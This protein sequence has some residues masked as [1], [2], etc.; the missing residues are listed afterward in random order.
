MIKRKISILLTVV[1]LINTMTSNVLVAERSM[2]TGETS[3]GSDIYDALGID[4]S[5]T[6]DGYNP[7]STEN[8][9]GKDTYVPN[10]VNELYDI[11]TN[12][13]VGAFTSVSQDKSTLDALNMSKTTQPMHLW[14][15][16]NVYG[17][18][19]N[20]DFDVFSASPINSDITAT[21]TLADAL[22][23]TYA[24]HPIK[25]IQQTGYLQ[26]SNL[27]SDKEP[28]VSSAVEGNFSGNSTGRE[29][30]VVMIY[31]KNLNRVNSV[32]I[33]IGSL[34][35]DENWTFGEETPI[36]DNQV[37]G[38]GEEGVGGRDNF[39]EAPFLLK[40][41][42]QI[43]TGDYNGDGIDEIAVYIP[44]L[45]KSRI[46]VYQLTWASSAE[47]YTDFGN[48]KHVWTHY[49]NETNYV[50]N[51]V[52]M[53]SG[54]VNS[55]NIDDLGVTWGYYYGPDDNK[56]SKA[57]IMFGE[58]TKMLQEH[59][60]ID[61]TYDGSSIVRS[62]FAFG[63][64]L[65][66]NKETLVLGGQLSTDIQNQNTT[67]RFITVYEWNGQDFIQS[68][69]LSRNFDLFAF[70]Q[71]TGR[72]IYQDVMFATSDGS[73][74]LEKARE[75][76]FLKDAVALEERTYSFYSSPLMPANIDI[77][78]NG[79]GKATGIYFDS[80]FFELN[81][82]DM[83]L[84]YTTDNKALMQNGNIDI[85]D[86]E[87]YVEYDLQVVDFTG[88][89]N[90]TVSTLA[91]YIN[92]KNTAS[93]TVI[94]PAT[95]IR[96]AYYK[97]WWN[98]LWKIKS[99]RD[100]VLEE[101]S[102]ENFSM[103]YIEKYAPTY[104]LSMNLDKSNT[105]AAVPEDLK[106]S[107]TN[108][109]FTSTL[110]SA[111]L[112]KNDTSYL[113]YTG[114]HSM[115][116][117][118][119]KVLAVVSS[120]PYF[121][122]LME[123]DDL[124]GAYNESTTSYGTSSSSGTVDGHTGTFTI[125][126]VVEVTTPASTFTF[127]AETLY[128]MT[129]T[130]ETNHNTTY[131]IEYTAST[132][133]DIIVL[134]S[135]PTAIYSYKLYNVDEHGN[136]NE[137]DLD[138]S[139]PYEPSVRLLPNST[140]EK[141]TE[142]FEDLPDVG[143][144]VLTH[145]LGDPTT[146]P[147]SLDNYQHAIA[148]KGDPTGVGFSSNAASI[149]QSVEITEESSEVFTNGFEIMTTYQWGWQTSFTGGSTAGFTV[150]GG[151]DWTTGKVEG[152]GSVFTA[153]MQNMP[154]EA[155]PYGYG[156][157]WK[158]FMHKHRM[159]DGSSI[160]VVNYL[161]SGVVAPPKLPQDFEQVIDNNASEEA[162]DYSRN[163]KLQWTYDELISGFEIY[164]EYDFPSGSGRTKIATVPFSKG[165]DVDS[166][167]V[168]EFSY[169]DTQLNPNTEYKYSIQAIGA[170]E[171]KRSIY[172][173][174]LV[175]RTTTDV[176]Y[177][178]IELEG[179]MTSTDTSVP[180]LDL[181]VDSAKSVKALVKDGDTLLDT[182]P[183]NSDGL[184]LQW[185]ALN[186]GVWQ[187]IPGLTADT[188]SFR[189]PSLKASG[190]QY[191][192]R[193][194]RVYY[195]EGSRETYYIST[196]SKKFQ[197][198]VSKYDVFFDE[199]KIRKNGE[200]YALDV[201]IKPDSFAQ[202][203]P[204]N[205]LSLSV[206]G[207]NF[208]KTLQVPLSP[209][210]GAGEA[211]LKALGTADLGVLND[212]I[213]SVTIA[214]SGD[215]KF[216][217]R[218][219][220]GEYPFVTGSSTSGYYLS[221]GEGGKSVFEYNAPLHLETFEVS[222]GAKVPLTEVTYK[223][224]K[225]DGS[226]L[227]DYTEGVNIQAGQ[228]IMYAYS[229]QGWL[230]DFKEFEI[231]PLDVIVRIV[232]ANPAQNTKNT[233]IMSKTDTGILPENENPRYAYEIVSDQYDQGTKNQ[234]IE[235]LESSALSFETMIVNTAGNRVEEEL[236][237]L[238]APS[239]YTIHPLA[240]EGL[241]SDYR[242]I[243]EQTQFIVYGRSLEVIV[244]VETINAEAAGEVSINANKEFASQYREGSSL[245]FMA[246][247]FDGYDFDGWEIINL[248]NG[249]PVDLEQEV[250]KES[251][252]NYILEEHPIKIIAN[253]KEKQRVVTTTITPN[254][255]AGSVQMY[256]GDTPISSGVILNKGITV[257]VIAKAN[258][259]YSFDK[260]YIDQTPSGAT[261]EH[262]GTKHPNGTYSLSHVVTD[263]SHA[264]ITAHFARDKYLLNLNG[265]IQAI[266]AKTGAAIE[267]GSKVSGDTLIELK[268]KE[269]YSVNE[270]AFWK[271]EGSTFD[272][273]EHLDADA[274]PTP[275][276]SITKPTTVSLSTI[277]NGYDLSVSTVTGGA[278]EIW[279]N[280]VKQRPGDLKL[281]GGDKMTLICKPEIGYRLSA[282][283]VNTVSIDERLE[284]GEPIPEYTID[285]ITSDID[286]EAEFSPYLPEETYSVQLFDTNDALEK[287]EYTYI[288]QYDEQ[289]PSQETVTGPAIE[290]YKDYS[291]RFDVSTKPGYAIK[292]WYLNDR[293]V[294]V[295]DKEYRGTSYILAKPNADA[296]LD[297]TSAAN[298]QYMFSYV[299]SDR[300]GVTDAMNN[301]I[302]ADNHVYP[303][304]KEFIIKAN[305][306]PE[307]QMINYWT[308]NGQV[309]YDEV[310][311][312]N[313]TTFSHGDRRPV[314]DE[315]IRYSLDQN[316][317]DIDVEFINAY[318]L[319]YN[320]PKHSKW[321]I[322]VDKPNPYRINADGSFTVQEGASATYRIEPERGYEI[323]SVSHNNMNYPMNDRLG[324]CI[325]TVDNI[326]SD[327]MIQAVVRKRS[328]Y[329][330]LSDLNI[331]GLKMS[332]AFADDIKEYSVDVDYLTESL[333]VEAI[334]FDKTSNVKI[335]GH[336]NLSAGKNTVQ[337][338]VTAEDGITQEM[339]TIYVT[340]EKAPSNE[341]RLSSL[342]I[343]GM[344]ISPEFHPDVKAYTASIDHTQTS[345]NVVAT[346]ME[347][348]ADVQITGHTGLVT[349][350]NK[351]QIIVTA[352]DG[353]SG[354]TYTLHVSKEAPPAPPS[355]GGGGGGIREEVILPSTD[356]FNEPVT[357][358][359]ETIILLNVDYERA[360][361][362]D[363]VVVDEATLL[364][365]VEQV[366]KES[367]KQKT[368]PH[369]QI[370][371]QSEK[372]I[373][374]LAVHMATEAIKNLVSTGQSALTLRTNS[375]TIT[376][377]A[378]AMRHIGENAEETF[379]L[380]FAKV[381]EGE[382]EEENENDTALTYDI[383]ILS[384]EKEIKTLSEGSA[385]VEIVYPLKKGQDPKG[386]NVYHINEAG[387]MNRLSST[388]DAKKEC[389]IFS[390]NH[391]SHYRV[392]YDVL[393]AWEIPYADVSSDTWYEQAVKYVDYHNYMRGTSATEF[394]PEDTMTRAMI[395][396]VL[397]R[398]EN[399]PKS[400]DAIAEYDD[401]D[402]Q[403]WYAQAVRWATSKNIVRGYSED[404]FG[405]DDMLTREQLAQIL[406]NY[407]NSKQLDT[408]MQADLTSYLDEEEIADWAFEAVSWANAQGVLTGTTGDVLAPKDSATRAQVAAIIMRFMETVYQ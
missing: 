163:I 316:I 245:I 50:S 75:Y 341:S 132:G 137:E 233:Y 152:T 37:I 128:N 12:F 404:V 5:M 401:I 340:K 190:T 364:S 384:G 149:I 253:F 392:T 95:T 228:Y 93:A 399:E 161:V 176:G 158:V 359:K 402:A 367:D 356:T 121:D 312:S 90:E 79:A 110:V 102:E 170:Q 221:L 204:T 314:I 258:P 103:E 344:E 192:L 6:P 78:K 13:D 281:Q 211:T 201:I 67:S 39:T 187:D 118:D 154:L 113:S 155:E 63:D 310:I 373:E 143:A 265:N 388:Y 374:T 205:L 51:M 84:V 378:R 4:N 361:K 290:I 271:I 2:P 268:V 130:V 177:P 135:V 94:T 223:Y 185:Q 207:D 178:S 242:F 28:V 71:E 30:D 296:K 111:N 327:T 33:R 347:A 142:V 357:V 400:F 104:L 397:W 35:D 122:D 198:N 141:L 283:E 72:F 366:M 144:S 77:V 322:V 83:N 408:R 120:P 73:V 197:L 10:P 119:P 105:G 106:S 156:Y 166:D 112:D 147:S 140:Y 248:D 285:S 127:N 150:G 295:D 47:D 263:A 244:D 318:T 203:A 18:N 230:I 165:T 304:G 9:Y 311:A 162:M 31:T 180:F 54:D 282:F 339:Y 302:P 336:T 235:V 160:P 8:P 45:N 69:S 240:K 276:F 171:P 386:I 393:Q 52:S 270:G 64:L 87:H 225:R 76:T 226:Q 255:D 191:R 123:R 117:S 193:V 60:D 328:D 351:V 287:I 11:T 358:D 174:T 98:K 44:E 1:L 321:S 294:K 267:N 97:N 129:H 365:M 353:V 40:N 21:G 346:S 239:S 348:T 65:G 333:N 189:S 89:E 109:N 38:N 66:V 218:R 320:Q 184:T 88:D 43:V 246:H 23:Q 107:R 136:V 199:A 153:E 48:W 220:I 337:V 286:V 396:T 183:N 368:S 168:Y 29:N 59:Y 131:S 195:D 376:L 200:K 349:G 297:V 125:G 313:M 91:Q 307:G 115:V 157:N 405:P 406:M 272:G 247:P 250:Q 179:L 383:N 335:V 298:I 58:S 42:L 301:P 372:T 36:I 186:N 280:D 14:Q 164:R 315:Q 24:W 151:T 234:M 15:S 134:Y 68:P 236:N 219:Y 108:K 369:V 232:N 99:Y 289:L 213:Y 377:D 227:Q 57:T 17:Y 86:F 101:G 274:N 325:F 16:I 206:T 323:V 70:D 212:G 249:N 332:P 231:A 7:Q 139:I 355:G 145:T 334:P 382:E 262:E 26:S 159:D 224:S 398:I 74:D 20:K 385:T 292:R 329:A 208:K 256:V 210:A 291:V 350:D 254:N 324:E 293:I 80:L 390:V 34:G 375:V 269:G 124:S 389:V 100:K 326:T 49:L 3:G 279:L 229:E 237:G 243:Y 172:S 394:L 116:Y 362:S 217:S 299:D 215:E 25:S 96:E 266:N 352:E 182:T 241:P 380:D 300:F 222:E 188:I 173:E 133:D 403:A 216:N 306:I 114:T 371:I 288:N 252:L 202:V 257:D 27:I 308:L 238:L 330:I 148:Y 56:P 19:V 278:V 387:K 175:A 261:G 275:T 260:W 53:V 126:P 196:Y 146:Y 62:S 305:N 169:I 360:K 342:Y 61:L 138:V 209:L 407:A 82:N 317:Y 181:K 167:K 338:L 331:E 32:Y 319:A 41:Y 345:V 379:I 284:N 22:S 81:N 381:N 277:A 370:N 363:T 354:N 194:N 309:L 92:V 273:Q 303:A 85:N 251:I 264:K 343:E 46:E 214:Y 395:V 55:D 259:G 391:F